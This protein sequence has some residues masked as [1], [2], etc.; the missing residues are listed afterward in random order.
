MNERLAWGGGLDGLDS[1]RVPEDC[2]SRTPSSNQPISSSFFLRDQACRRWPGS[3]GP[4]ILRSH[5]SSLSLPC[6]PSTWAKTQKN[7]ANNIQRQ[8]PIYRA[9]WQPM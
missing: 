8:P 6:T 7:Y 4:I 2:L 3:S 1:Q 9:A 5:S